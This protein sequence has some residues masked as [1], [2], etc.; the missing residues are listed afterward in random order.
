MNVENKESFV[1]FIYKKEAL[2]SETCG[3]TNTFFGVDE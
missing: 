3:P 1:A 2:R